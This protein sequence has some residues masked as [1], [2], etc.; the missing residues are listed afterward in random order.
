MQSFFQVMRRWFA[1]GVT[2]T[3][4]PDGARLTPWHFRII[5][6]RDA[7]GR[8]VAETPFH[9]TRLHVA[10]RFRFGNI[11]GHAGGKTEMSN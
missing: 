3:P 9:F 10:P 11:Q 7:D 4:P 2:D 6:P 8:P 1:G 5:I